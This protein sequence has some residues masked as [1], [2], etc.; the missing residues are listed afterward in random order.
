MLRDDM[1]LLL[2]PRQLRHAHYFT[3]IIIDAADLCAIAS[4]AFIRLPPSSPVSPIRRHFI[5]A[6][7]HRPPAARAAIF[8][9]IICCC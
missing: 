5:A 4:A 1:L 2:L 7:H 3:L 8:I 9:I 6:R